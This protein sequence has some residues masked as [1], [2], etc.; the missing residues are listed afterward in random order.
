MTRRVRID[1][2]EPLSHGWAKLDRYTIRYTRSDGR[3]DVLVREVHDHGHGA[4]VLPYDVRRGRARRAPPRQACSP[5]VA[6]STPR[7]TR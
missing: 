1:K 7:P 2:V 6:T 3:E 5:R 4:T